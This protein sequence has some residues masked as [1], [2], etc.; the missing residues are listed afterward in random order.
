MVGVVEGEVDNVFEAG[1]ST[2]GTDGGLEVV[3][4]GVVVVGGGV[5]AVGLR[6]V[7]HG[8]GGGEDGAEE[9]ERKE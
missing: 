6:T 1:F 4:F 3:G 9:Q 7:D 8:G 5:G 2:R